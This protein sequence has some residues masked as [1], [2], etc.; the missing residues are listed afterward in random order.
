M[1]EM[2]EAVGHEGTP[3]GVVEQAVGS[4]FGCN[5]GGETLEEQPETGA[6]PRV[7]FLLHVSFRSDRDTDLSRS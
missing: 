2:G 5:D 7:T 3:D 6:L 1:T 4:E